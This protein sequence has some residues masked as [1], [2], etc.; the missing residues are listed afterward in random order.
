MSFPK[1]GEFPPDFALCNQ[2][3]RLVSLKDFHN[4]GL[5]R[6]RQILHR[7]SL[8]LHLRGFEQ[9]LASEMASKTTVAA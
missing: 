8:S 9:N 5:E 3:G 7:F 2:D 6:F 1:L 4:G